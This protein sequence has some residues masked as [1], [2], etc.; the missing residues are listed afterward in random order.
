LPGASRGFP[1]I[2]IVAFII[3]GGVLEG[4]PAIVLLGPLLFTLDRACSKPN[5]GVAIA[6]RAILFIDDSVL[7]AERR[8]SF[9]AKA[10]R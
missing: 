2:T 9:N 3:L 10:P 8:L 6:R 1:A 4:L 5:S 7:I